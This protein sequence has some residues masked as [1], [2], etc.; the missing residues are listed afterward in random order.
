MYLY[1][2]KLQV[3]SKWAT[4][5]GDGVSG[6]PLATMLIDDLFDSVDRGE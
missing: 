4:C 1:L 2:E 5:D 6:S 3:L